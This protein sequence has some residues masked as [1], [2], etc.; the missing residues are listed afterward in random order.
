M[1]AAY[2]AAAFALDWIYRHNTAKEINQVQEEQ[3]QKQDIEAEKEQGMSP[4][5]KS[6]MEYGLCGGSKGFALELAHFAR[7]EPE[8]IIYDIGSGEDSPISELRCSNV[9]YID[10]KYRQSKNP[11]SQYCV[12]LDDAIHRWKPAEH[13][14]V[15]VILSW[16]FTL[17]DTEPEKSWDAQALCRLRILYGHQL[18]RI[19]VI[20]NKGQNSGSKSLFDEL[21]TNWVKV[22]CTCQYNTTFFPSHTSCEIYIQK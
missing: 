20:T 13:Q 8:C 12:S 2:V 15:R 17:Y 16:P 22:R 1:T 9:A 14:S 7:E 10:I 18:V 11:N 6:R 21:R 4:L 19:M 5:I 3:E